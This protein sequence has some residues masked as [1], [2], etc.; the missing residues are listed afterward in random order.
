VQDTPH[1]PCRAW[2]ASCREDQA[3]WLG[4]DQ[5]LCAPRDRRGQA[6]ASP[7]VPGEPDYQRTANAGEVQAVGLIT[8]S[9]STS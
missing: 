2:A 5:P 7:P 9:N 3:A 4:T 6:P 8:A 1:P